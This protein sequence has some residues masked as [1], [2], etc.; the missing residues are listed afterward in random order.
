MQILFL[1]TIKSNILLRFIN[2]FVV[3]YEIFDYFGAKNYNFIR[4]NWNKNKKFS[5]YNL[6][7]MWYNTI[8][9]CP[10]GCV[11]NH[12]ESPSIIEQGAGEIPVR[13]TLRK[14][15]Q[16]IT[17]NYLVRVKKQGKSLLANLVIYALCK[18]H[19]MQG[20]KH[21]DCSSCFIHRL[22]ISVMLCLD[23]CPSNTELGL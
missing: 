19:P 17:A 10:D 9:S 3:I 2:N 1:F 5:L 18:P 16:K 20:K 22:S 13:V 11:S 23:R 12:E 7:F 4:N 8:V 14:V 21:I 15:Q 6:I